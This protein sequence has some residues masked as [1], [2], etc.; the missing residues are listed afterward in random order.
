[1]KIVENLVTF[2]LRLKNSPGTL[3]KVLTVIGKSGGSMGNI[4]IIQADKDFKIRDLAVYVSTDEQVQEIVATLSALG[5][6]VVEVIAVKDKVFELHEKGKIYLSN[7]ISIT[8]FEDLSRVY[9]PGVAKVCRAIQT[10]PELAREYTIIRNTV[11]VVTD[12]TAILG[13]G[14]IGPVAGMPVMEG[15]AMLFKAFGNID[16]FP[17][18]VNTKDTEEIIKTVVNISPT[19]GGINLEDISAP[20]C[21]EIERR[22]KEVLP[23]PVFHDDQHGTAVVCLAGLLN[24]L[25][26]AGKKIE[27]VSTVISGAGAAGISIAQMLIGAGAKGIVVCDTS[28]I[29]YKGRAANMNTAKEA[30]AQITN[31]KNEKGT[32]ADAMRGKDVFIGVSGP[33]TITRDMV[34]TMQKDSIVFALANPSPEVEPD[35][36]ED[37]A[38]II[39]TGRS[40]YHNQIN[41]VLCFPGLF[42]GA[43]DSG[44]TAITDTMN[45]AAAY[46][47]A[48]AIEEEHLSEDYIIPSVFN[49]K[50]H[51]DVAR[52][53]A[54]AA[55][56]SGVATRHLL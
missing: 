5:R 23:I 44:A 2:R 28:G 51:K 29:I 25:R 9:T 31:P 17:I 39:A 46:A 18:L 55:V 3:G 38:R 16:A 36:I 56:K 33:N 13:L 19:F 48:H 14:D 34:K 52:A 15:K 24:A 11:A 30:L 40:D 27:N 20:R 49:E 6:D 32:I 37:I 35:L 4:Q 12:G 45:M 22:L 47:I 43:L 54:D 42:R 10:R 7:R 50:V 41:N 21:F 1:M 26:V 53:V 8:T